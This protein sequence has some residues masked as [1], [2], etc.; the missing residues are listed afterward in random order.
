MGQNVARL[1]KTVIPTLARKYLQMEPQEN[2]TLITFDTDIETIVVPVGELESLNIVSRGFSN[3]SGVF[4]AII[5]TVN[6]DNPCVRIICISDG[7]VWDQDSTLKEAARA[8]S[9]L[10]DSFSI[11][12]LAVRLF[13]SSAQPDTRALASILQLNTEKAGSI[14]DMEASSDAQ[15]LLDIADTVGAQMMDS[16]GTVFSLSCEKPCLLRV[17]WPEPSSSLHLR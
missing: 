17:P 1:T 15:G 13:T 16:T 14:I 8:A 2:L 10:K 7:Q 4:D 5:K 12:A 3:M 11:S 9:I 6:Y